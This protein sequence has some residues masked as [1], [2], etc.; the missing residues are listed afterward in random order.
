[1]KKWAK[2]FKV[3]NA[4]QRSER[5]Y[6]ERAGIPSASALGNLFDTKADGTPSAKSKEYRKELAFERAFNTTFKR[7]DTKAMQDGRFYE[8]FAKR[9]YQKD[10][11][12]ELL[13]A[14]SY[15]S[16]YFVATPD[17][18]IKGEKGLLECKV[19]GDGTFL[20]IIENGIPLAHELQVQGQ[21]LTTGYDWVDYIVVNLKTR[22]YMTIR[23]ERNNKIIKRIYERLHE[24]LDLP[25]IDTIKV[26]RFDQAE[27]TDYM[28]ENPTPEEQN[29]I[30]H[31]PF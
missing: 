14:F 8:D 22:A 1:M 2:D 17:A 16:D 10:T 15:I 28:G 6:K 11:G 7:F 31:M 5:W 9:M 25:K 27:L 4:P 24:P 29:I 13:E 23:V 21:M 18:L 30:E 20:D 19:V 12:K 3:S 26:K